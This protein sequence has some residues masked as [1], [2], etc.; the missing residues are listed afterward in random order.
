MELHYHKAVP[1]DVEDAVNVFPDVNT[2]PASAHAWLQV[3]TVL[4]MWK[5]GPGYGKWG[6]MVGSVFERVYSDVVLEGWEAV[7]AGMGTGLCRC[8][9]TLNHSS[10]GLHAPLCHPLAECYKVSC[11]G[12]TGAS[13]A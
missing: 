5:L 13:S 7:S 12:H 4:A 10:C 6:L 1:S 11:F 9:A 8:T 2:T 3:A